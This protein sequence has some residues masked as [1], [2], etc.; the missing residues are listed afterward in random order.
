MFLGSW[1]HIRSCRLG[2]AWTVFGVWAV[3][4]KTIMFLIY[5]IKKSS[6][7]KIIIY[8]T[9]FYK[10]N[11]FGTW[12][13]WLLQKLKFRV[14]TQNKETRIFGFCSI[15]CF[16]ENMT[17]VS[18]EILSRSAIFCYMLSSLSLVP[19]ILSLRIFFIW[20]VIISAFICQKSFAYL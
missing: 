1:R 16:F 8:G 4:L 13:F 18:F 19:L 10:S 11:T 7:K 17:T 12:H 2:C 20:K 5:L 14:Y 6:L 15:F 3:Y 9:F